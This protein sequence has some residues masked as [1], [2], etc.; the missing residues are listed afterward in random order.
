MFYVK[1]VTRGDVCTVNDRQLS[2]A[3]PLNSTE[4]FS[5]SQLVALAL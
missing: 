4:H 5:V 3:T 1:G 2:L